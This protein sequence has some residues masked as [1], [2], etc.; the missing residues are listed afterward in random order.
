MTNQ[1]TPPRR[2]DEPDTRELALTQQQFL[3]AR[4]Q[5]AAERTES[6]RLDAGRREWDACQRRQRTRY[7]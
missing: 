4:A 2:V 5:L 7:S 3:F 6:P 1:S